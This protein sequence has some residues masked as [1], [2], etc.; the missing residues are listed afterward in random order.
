MAFIP[1]KRRVLFE[2]VPKCDLEFWFLDLLASHIILNNKSDTDFCVNLKGEHKVLFFYVYGKIY[3]RNDLWVLLIT[4]LETEV[5][6][7]KFVNNFF[8]KYYPS[9]KNH[10]VL[11]GNGLVGFNVGQYLYREKYGYENKK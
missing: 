8:E 1:E 9:L 6:L 10:T 11:P 2:K 3:L 7:K 4:K 5:S